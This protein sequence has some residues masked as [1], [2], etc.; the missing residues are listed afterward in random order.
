M[1]K[2]IN[3]ETKEVFLM[4]DEKTPFTYSSKALAQ[5]G[6]ASLELHHKVKLAVVPA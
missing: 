5:Q 1:F 4:R 2:L 6:K 3:R